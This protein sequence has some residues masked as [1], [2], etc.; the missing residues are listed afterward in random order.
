[1][2]VKKLKENSDYCDPKKIQ[3]WKE[4]QKFREENFRFFISFVFKFDKKNKK[5]IKK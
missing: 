1:M 3:R 2:Q 5:T 4:K